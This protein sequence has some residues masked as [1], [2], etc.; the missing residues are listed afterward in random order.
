MLDG[1]SNEAALGAS[2]GASLTEREVTW[3]MQNEFAKRADD[4][5]WRRSKLGLRMTP[6]QID[7]LDEWMLAV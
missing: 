4:V 6:D 7:A 5:V 3:L 1:A 2:F